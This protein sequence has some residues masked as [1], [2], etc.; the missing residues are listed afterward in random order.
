[1][2]ER[3]GR[4][5]QTRGRGCPWLAAAAHV[6]SATGSSLQAGP[7]SVKPVRSSPSEDP[8]AHPVYLEGRA[9]TWA[10]TVLG[11][12]LGDLGDSETRKEAPS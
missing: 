12:S 8:R 4:S 7:S 2:P 3:G 9:R 5:A 11:T 10:F 1:M 6:A